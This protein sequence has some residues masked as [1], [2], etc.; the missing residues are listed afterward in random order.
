MIFNRH[1]YKLLWRIDLANFPWILLE[2]LVFQI[3]KLETCQSLFYHHQHVCFFFDPCFNCSCCFWIKKRYSASFG[4][5]WKVRAG[6]IWYLTIWYS[7][8]GRYVLLLTEMHALIC[9]ITSL[10]YYRFCHRNN[11]QNYF[12]A[13]PE[14]LLHSFCLLTVSHKTYVSSMFIAQICSWSLSFHCSKRLNDKLLMESSFWL[15]IDFGFSVYSSMWID[16]E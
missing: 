16:L 14:L 1:N 13:T 2:L 4:D 10:V 3:L 8:A 7:F 15:F 5:E 6:L 11:Y 9:T 12:R